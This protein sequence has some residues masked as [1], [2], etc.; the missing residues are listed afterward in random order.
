MLESVVSWHFF[1][2]DG[3]CSRLDAPLVLLGRMGAELTCE[4][5]QNFLTYPAPLRE[6]RERKVV[7]I[8]FSQT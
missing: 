6:R 3:Q 7:R 1:V 2:V 8:N 4:H 5:I